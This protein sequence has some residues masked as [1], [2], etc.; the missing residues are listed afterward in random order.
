MTSVHYR[1]VQHDGGWAY[2]VGDVFSESF[3]THTAALEAAKS[4]A[5]RQLQPGQTTGIQ[6][7]D[8][9]GQW[10]EEVARGTD[11]PVTDVEDTPSA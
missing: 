11:R 10:H 3:A 2:Q 9:S 7:Q 6:Y 5:S 1:I 8:E 4:A